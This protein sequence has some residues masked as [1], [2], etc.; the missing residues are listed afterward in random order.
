M[1]TPINKLIGFFY[2]AFGGKPDLLDAV[3]TDDWDDIPLGPAS[4][5]GR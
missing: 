2:E 4:S 5:R 1:A 3:I